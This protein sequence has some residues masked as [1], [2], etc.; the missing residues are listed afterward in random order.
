[1]DRSGN[2]FQ[3]EVQLGHEELASLHTGLFEA[4]V[5]VLFFGEDEGTLEDVFLQVTKGGL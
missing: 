2:E 3:F 5:R 4:G 1:M